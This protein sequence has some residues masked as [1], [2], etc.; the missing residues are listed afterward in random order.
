MTLETFFAQ[1][2]DDYIAVTPR[3]Q[4]VHDAFIALFASTDIRGGRHAG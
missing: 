3:A 4:R 2:W 1:L